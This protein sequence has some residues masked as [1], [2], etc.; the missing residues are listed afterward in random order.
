MSDVLERRHRQVAVEALHLLEHGQ[1]IRGLVRTG[2][3][4]LVERR[5]VDRLERVER[6][7]RHGP[8]GAAQGRLFAALG[9]LLR[10]PPVHV[11]AVARVHATHVDALDGAG[12]RAL[13]A[14]F[15]LECAGFVVDEDEPTTVARADLVD[16]LGIAHGEVRAK[17][18]AH[19]EDH[20]LDDGQPGDPLGLHE[21]YSLT[22]MMAP[23]VMKMFRSAAGI[24]HFQAKF[25]IWSMRTRG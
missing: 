25:I 9:V 19:G 12:L 6:A 21:K 10:G 5:Q 14:G 23:A 20:A 7:I 17:D 2:A 1:R 13:E 8:A 18:L 15:A 22:M 11:V 24:S 16:D 3:E 4:D